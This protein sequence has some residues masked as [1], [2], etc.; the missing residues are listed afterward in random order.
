MKFKIGDTVT[1]LK[2]GLP[3]I[4]QVFAHMSVESFINYQ[5][6]ATGHDYLERA[7]SWN[8]YYPKWMKKGKSVYFVLFPEPQLPY[9][10]DDLLLSGGTPEQ[11]DLY[12][13]VGQ[14]AHCATYPEDDLI[15]YDGEPLDILNDF[16]AQRVKNNI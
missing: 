10:R 5:K 7:G 8:E 15:L 3:G 9:S 16:M 12:I 11:A 14:K 2:T 1:F 13:K 6:I 4:G